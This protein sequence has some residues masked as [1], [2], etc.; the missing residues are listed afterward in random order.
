MNTTTY[1][2]EQMRYVLYSDDPEAEVLEDSLID[3]SRWSTH[4]NLV[5]KK[6]GKTW[7]TQYSRGAT[8]SQDEQP[9]EYQDKVVCMEVH[10]V[11]KTVMVWEPVV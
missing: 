7:E 9:F 10:Q 1:T 8:E 2:G 11:P 3:T 6:D 5:F 4:H